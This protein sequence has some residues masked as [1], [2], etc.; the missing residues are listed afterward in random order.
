MSMEQG[1]A[2]LGMGV[3]GQRDARGDGGRVTIEAV[4]LGAV[5]VAVLAALATTASPIGERFGDAVRTLLCRA[6]VIVTGEECPS[7]S[8]A[9]MLAGEPVHCLTQQVARSVGGPC[10]S[11]S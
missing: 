4:A 6:A 5:L 7:P 1:T 8:A 2:R 9:P 3:T 10:V 11:P